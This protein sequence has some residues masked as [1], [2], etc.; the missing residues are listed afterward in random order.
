[1]DKPEPV[2]QAMDEAGCV[3]AWFAGHDHAGGYYTRKGVHHVTLKGM[4]EAPVSNAYAL[5]ELHPGMIRETGFG[6][7]PSREMALQAQ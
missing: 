4:V 6:K 3:A 2:L 1:M 7:E 5:I